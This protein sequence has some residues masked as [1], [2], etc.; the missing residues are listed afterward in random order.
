M[1]SDQLGQGV[2]LTW[3]WRSEFLSISVYFDSGNL[4]TY[5]MCLSHGLCDVYT[6]EFLSLN[7]LLM[8]LRK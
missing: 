5:D 8:T 3:R 7:G 1:K 4:C 6:L 2:K